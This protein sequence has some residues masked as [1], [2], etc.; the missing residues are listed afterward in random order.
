MIGLLRS[1]L[2]E[3][4]RMNVIEGPESRSGKSLSD[5]QWRLK[6]VLVLGS[7]IASRMT[8]EMS[9]IFFFPISRLNN[10]QYYHLPVFASSLAVADR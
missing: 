3:E 10:E 1:R 9:E 6:E 2:K 4:A 7:T 5:L 8:V